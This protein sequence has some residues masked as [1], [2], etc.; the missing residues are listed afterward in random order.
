MITE[1]FC[2]GCGKKIPWDHCAIG[3]SDW[4]ICMKCEGATVTVFRVTC[5]GSHYID[6][7]TNGVKII[8]DNMEEGDVYTISRAEMR[9]AEYLSLPKF[10]GGR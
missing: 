9:L 1:R 7:D 5:D 4:A 8:I 2:A 3:N 6:R 10:R